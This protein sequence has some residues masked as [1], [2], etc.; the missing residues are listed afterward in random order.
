MAD[1]CI[2]PLYK[3][4]GVVHGCLILK[5]ATPFWVARGSSKVEKVHVNIFK[6]GE[7]TRVAGIVPVFV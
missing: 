2:N 6:V 4:Y 7:Q 5:N 3:G 1:L